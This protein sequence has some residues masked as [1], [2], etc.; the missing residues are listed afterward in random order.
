MT[1]KNLG[2]A[3]EN[4]EKLL[5]KCELKISIPIN[6]TKQNLDTQDSS[7]KPFLDNDDLISHIAQRRFFLA[8]E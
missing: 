6:H 1:F 5:E 2:F 8:G 7:Q 3:T 4:L